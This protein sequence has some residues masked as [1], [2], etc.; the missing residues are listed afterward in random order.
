MYN[1][2]RKAPSELVVSSSHRGEVFACMV[3]ISSFRHLLL[4]APFKI[5]SD[6]I[7]VRYLSNLK[8]MRAPFPRYYALLADFTFSG[9]H[10]AGCLNQPDDTISRRSD[11]P[12]MDKFER[13]FHSAQSFV[14]QMTPH[15]QL[16]TF[17][18]RTRTSRT[19][20][21]TD[22]TSL[23]A[24]ED[25]AIEF[26]DPF[27]QIWNLQVNTPTTCLPHDLTTFDMIT[28]HPTTSPFCLDSHP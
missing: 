19:R 25:L 18:T 7:S 10:R 12:E 9:E 21:R 13:D 14:D 8:D 23:E 26:A 11:L 6:S 2:S 20:T 17:S 5:K 22:H 28:P 15:S 24:L 1:V 27:P 16:E 4:L 3:G